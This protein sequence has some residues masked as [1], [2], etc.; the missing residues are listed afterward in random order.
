[1][2]M[3]DGNA[4]VAEGQYERIEAP[5]LLITSANFRPMTEGVTM[6]VHLKADGNKTQFTF[7]V[8]HPTAEYC[9]AQE[10]MGFYN[11]WGS[12]FERLAGML[13]G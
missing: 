4:F 11:G 1:M 8:I 12:A 9:K 2:K 5:T 3:K 10:E 6:E 7:N 13:E